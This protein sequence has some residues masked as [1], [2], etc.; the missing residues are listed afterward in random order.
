M[1]M[2][3]VCGYCDF[4][5]VVRGRYQITTTNESYIVQYKEVAPIVSCTISVSLGLSQEA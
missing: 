4:G 2:F 1:I 5:G 3:I